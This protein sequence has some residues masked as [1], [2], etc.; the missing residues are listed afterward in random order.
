M[1]QSQG[2]PQKV[3]SSTLQDIEKLAGEEWQSMLQRIENESD[4]AENVR[5][6]LLHVVK[7]ALLGAGVL[8]PE[9]AATA[10]VQ[11][12]RHGPEIPCPLGSGHP[13]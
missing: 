2:S 13:Q 4:P 9:C 10:A 12:L 1:E 7:D 6:R 8:T 3:T 5:S 11:V